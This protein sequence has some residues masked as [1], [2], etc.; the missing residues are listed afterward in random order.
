EAV[1]HYRALAEASPVAYLPNLASSLN[2]L[3]IQQGKA[4]D[5]QA[6]LA[7][8]TEAVE[9]RRTLVEA[10]LA[11][12]L[13]DL[14]GSLNNL[15]VRQ[16]ETGDRQA[17]LAS[18]TEAVDHYRTLAEASPVAY[19]PD[20][21][22]SLNN[23]SNRQGETGDRQ[24][25][26]ASV[27]EAVEIRRTLAEASP[28]AY[29]PDLAMSLN[30]L[31]V[32]Q[33]ETGDW[34][35]AL[36]SV[37]EAVD[38]YRALAEAS[39]A[40][41]LPDLAT[42]L[43]NLSVQQ[44]EAG[45]RQAALA[46]IT[47]AVDHYRALAEASPA[48]YLPNFASSLNNLSNRQS[49]AGD[50]QGALASITEAVEIRRTLVEAN[51][52][53]YLPDLATSLNNLSVRQSETG[54]QQV[55]MAS[56]T[57]AVDHYRTLAEASPA[58]YL[59]DL[60]GSLNNLSIQQG[61]TGDRQGALASITEAVEIRR[62]LAEASPAAYLPDLAMSLNNLSNQQSK[63]EVASTVWEDAI[64]DLELNPLSQ[65]ELRA[66]YAT[67]LATHVAVAPAAD[68]LVR[69]A[70]ACTGGSPSPL[71]RARQ[72]VRVTVASLGIQD[73]RLPDWAVTPLPDDVLELLN[74]WA[75]AADW[76][77][78]E[79]FLRAHADRL[80][81]PGFRHHLELAEALFPESPPIDSLTSILGQVDADGIDTV[82]DR[83][84]NDHDVRQLLQEW[85]AT[86][87]WADSK[88]FLD[89]HS[90]KLRTPEVWALLAATDA[91]LAR[92]HLAILQ[93]TDDLPHNQVYEI[94]TDRNVA[95]EQ[96]FTAID[97]AAVPL[98]RHILYAHPD[99]LTDITGAFFATVITAANGDT[100]QARQLA[101]TIAE[102][103]TDTQRHA[104][105]IRL[106]T[107]AQL[108]PELSDANEI[109]DLIHPDK[110]P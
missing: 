78:V 90:S 31:S 32:L 87:T 58:A 36:A 24:G 104:Y 89:E 63:T 46:S 10:N 79:T 29:L 65:A 99:L 102:H 73:P 85:I 105:A 28:V 43:N 60:A 100:Y 15:S 74:Q 6:A 50:R 56:I 1:D 101:Q 62:T 9:I 108:G 41:Y 26:L 42:S 71:G 39:P 47:E 34:Q 14:A 57:E 72:R 68:Q 97:Q 16:S 76:P 23:L 38:H 69:A 13:P 61:E 54:D 55:A 22:M 53:A 92:L 103:G 70:L 30:N 67:Y 91:P 44:S 45:D 93:L 96:A 94:V 107:L 81:Q 83:G 4:G 37:I 7:S 48:A 64:T 95:T 86:P 52:A 49:E 84:R 77:S 33:G 5:R 18:I 2:N 12:Y 35:A 106:R 80:R 8:I 17:A 109:A 21:A 98:L 59:P 51:L 88:S 3:S 19:L 40:A 66:H 75:Q 20:L 25:A 27:I 11:A 110:H 82:L